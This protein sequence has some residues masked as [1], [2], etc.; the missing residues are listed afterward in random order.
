M[1]GHHIV[2]RVPVLRVV[3]PFAAG[4]ALWQWTQWWLPPLALLIAGVAGYA[5]LTLASRQPTGRLRCRPWFVAPLTIVALALGWLC[6]WLHE[7][8]KLDLD[9]TN[10]KTLIGRIDDMRYT[11]YSMR[12]TVRLLDVDDSPHAVPPCH[13]LVTTR[14]CDYRLRTG[15]LVALT[16]KLSEVRN[17]GNPDEMDYAAHLLHSQGIRYQQ[18]LPVS[19]MAACGYAPTWR[20]RLTHARD[21]LQR[22]LYGTRLPADA[23]QFIAALLLGNS[24][25]IDQATRKQFS[26]AG[27]AHVLA[28]SGLHVGIIALIIWW[29]LFPLDYVRLKRLRLV[30]TMAFI[31][32]FALFT[33]LSPSVVR[34]TVMIGF[35][36]ASM[37]L[38]RRSTSLNALAAAALGI[39]VFSPS[40]L[41]SVGF[42]LSFVTVGALL[43]FPHLFGRLRINNRIAN[44]VWQT[45]ITS[46]VATLATVGLTAHYFH[47]ISLVS[48]LANLLVVPVL[49]VFMVCG[50]LLLLLAA[51]GYQV[52]MLNWLVE[53]LHSYI[54]WAAR[55]SGSLPLSHVQGVYVTTAGTV[56]YM[57]VLAL[58]V[59][60]LYRRRCRYLMA[61]LAVVA[62]AVAHCIW[63]TL[64]MPRQGLVIFNSFAATPVLYHDH[65]TAWMWVPDDPEPD[66]ATYWQ[67]Y[68]AFFAHRAIDSLVIV[69]ADNAL[70]LDGALFKPPAAMLMG[71]RMVAAGRGS[72]AG[73]SSPT[74]ADESATTLDYLI[75]TRNCR[76]SATSLRAT[77][78][79]QQLVV[80][81]ALYHTAH[82]PLVDECDS[83]HIPYH[84]LAS[85]G[86]LVIEQ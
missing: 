74:Q 55:W 15:D 14:G 33:G 37:V 53:A 29:L 63:I 58:I 45:V 9:Q 11:D 38:Y 64:H 85:A 76:R 57:T 83:L 32:M 77:Y 39:L 73:G 54:A 34:A 30:L 72:R 2:S 13:L 3:V 68:R 50:A 28:L 51:A 52:A 21:Q 10:G 75:V 41:Y 4:I 16:A 66:A 18:H 1:T 79:Y 65:G 82:D 84:D 81:G 36:F 27:V 60:W 70:R 86:A 59:M 7:P 69:P 35:V 48:V 42:Q 49:P 23:Q 78:N 26:V 6:A 8:A 20:T 62:V 25:L 12:L 19:K 31:V 24:T 71:K 80:S 44:Y 43:I 47:T 22:Q 5:L 61:T 46:L 56:L 17:M 67:H 40:S